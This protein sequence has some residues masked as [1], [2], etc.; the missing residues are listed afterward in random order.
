M[1]QSVKSVLLLIGF[2]AMIGAIVGWLLDPDETVWMTRAICTPLAIVCFLAYWKISVRQDLAPDYLRSVVSNYFDRNGLTFSIIA[3]RQDG[4]CHLVAF[5][6]N[7]FERRCFGQIGIRPARGFWLNRAPV[8]EVVFSFE[9]GQAEFGMTSVAIPL[10]REL[11]GKTLSFDVG[12][13]V[14][15]P[16]GKGKRLRFRDG[17][18]LRH[19]SNFGNPFGTALFAA[20]ALTGQIVIN[21]PATIT[22]QLPIEVADE[23]PIRGFPS[24]QTFWQ[25]GDPPIENLAHAL[26]P[27]Q[28]TESPDDSTDL[29]DE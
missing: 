1:Q 26:N 12:A 29:E 18:F 22:I 13:S 14:D 5:F 4:V 7:Q 24:V 8:E 21:S 3:V 17:I 11:Q 23:L 10:P 15:Y 2:C 16:D 20:G 19:N 9:C 27:T 28:G 6:Q 25:L